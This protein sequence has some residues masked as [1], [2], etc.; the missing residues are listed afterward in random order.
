MKLR[1]APPRQ[2]GSILLVTLTSMMII[3]IALLTYLTLAKNQNQ[4]VARSQTWNACLPLAEAGLD[5][6]LN[7][8]VWN[9][10]NLTASGW[11]KSNTNS[12]YRTNALG[13]GYYVVTISTNITPATIIAAGYV[14]MPGSPDYVSRRVKV[15]A[16][17]IPPYTFAMRVKNAVNMNG[18]GCLIDSYDSS[19][20]TKSTGGLYDAA[21]AGDEADISLVS[22]SGSVDI[23]NGNIWGRAIIAPGGKVKT[24]ANGAV[25]SKAWNL[26]KSGV[27][28]GWTRSDANLSIPD[29]KVPFTGGVPP[30]P[31]I[32]GGVL[33]SAVLDGGAFQMSTMLG[34]VIIT[35]DSMVYVTG[36]INVSSLVIQSNATV[37]IY[38]GGTAAFAA[39]NN[40][41]QL[42]SAC[43]F[44]G[45][46]TCTSFD[47]ASEW[48]GT[49]YAPSADFGAAGGAD[50]Y[51]S[52]T[53]KSITLKGH[54]AYHFD[55]ALKKPQTTDPGF[56]ITSWIEL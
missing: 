49:V 33:Y 39:Q 16:S 9:T 27:Q 22:Q 51:G 42:A 15:E 36:N 50:F 40:K 47:I 2:Q 55:A 4:I 56:V 53:A 23:G 46:P 3:G 19:D 12:Y 10:T 41:T 7:H 1:L 20:S 35:D 30:L 25:G 5:D 31:G 11:T 45:L 17:M 24:G 44:F 34:K 8:L 29:A 14:P 48:I 38:C 13:E 18:N 32:V 26:S 52:C 6:A 43:M 37:R 21:K 28:P 54:S